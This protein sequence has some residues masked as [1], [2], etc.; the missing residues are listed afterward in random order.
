VECERF[1]G[2]L[3]DLLYGDLDADE[4]AFASEHRSQC[5]TCS[6]LARELE[7]ARDAVRE[8]GG[9]PP[10]PELDRA[11]SL[12]ARAAV[13]TDVRRAPLRGSGLH[14]AAAV[15]LAVSLGALGFALG[16]S[17]TR[18]SSEPPP[19]LA[20]DPTPAPTD[21]SV[22]VAN[23]PTPPRRHPRELPPSHVREWQRMNVETGRAKLAAGDVALAL[24][25]FEQAAARGW[26]T[27]LGFEA[28][29]G[30][31]E[32]QAAAGKRDA[33]LAALDELAL[34]VKGDVLQMPLPGFAERLAE[35]ERRIR[36]R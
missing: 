8:L 13:E 14:V 15:I 18:R 29:L 20:I 23:A 11:V 9:L 17:S 21:S 26:Y 19:S 30:M 35:V 24:T 34:D 31:A 28:R 27:D 16:A 6:G 33:A 7:E 32:A 25:C 10:P 36:G 22:P 5:P 12:A 4:R 2:A 1:Q 3:V